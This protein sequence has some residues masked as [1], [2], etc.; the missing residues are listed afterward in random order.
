M[1][2]LESAAPA[3][4]N[5]TLRVSGARTDGY[6]GI[7]SLT[8]RIG[9]CDTVSVSPAPFGELSLRCDDP[10]LPVDGA[11]LALRAARE[12]ARG[13]PMRGAQLELRKRI[14]AGAGLGGGSSDAATTLSLLNEFWG[15]GLGR[16]ELSAIGAAIGSDVPLFFAAPLCVL[17][18]RGVDVQSLSVR[19]A[20]WAVLVFPGIHCATAAVYAAWDRIA[21]HA[22]RPTLACVLH[23]L[24]RSPAGAM[25][26]LF[27]DLE[28][29]AHVVSPELARF[30]ARLRARSIAPFRMTGSGSTYF[31]LAD[32]EPRAQRIAGDVSAALGVRTAVAALGSA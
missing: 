1:P 31:T 17:R 13:G 30:A 6:H 32:D 22:A 16:D 8:A 28:A 7:E 18:G 2:T 10:A 24:Q 9:L 27:N 25:D 4:L 21:E 29:A 14:P 12:L 19:L 20:G 5:L 15:R 3:K 26:L 11:N 23:A